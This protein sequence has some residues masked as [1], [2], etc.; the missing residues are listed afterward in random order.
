VKKGLGKG[1]GYR[2][3][4]PMTRETFVSLVEQKFGNSNPGR[5]MKWII[6]SKTGFVEM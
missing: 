1:Q 4:D 5:G 3:L 2:T 6:T